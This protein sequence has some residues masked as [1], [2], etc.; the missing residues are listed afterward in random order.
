M[1]AHSDVLGL[2]SI[3]D[4]ICPSKTSKIILVHGEPKALNSLKTRLIMDRYSVYVP[5]KGEEKDI[6]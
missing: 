5:K 4:E 3:I 1:S 2:T 6:C